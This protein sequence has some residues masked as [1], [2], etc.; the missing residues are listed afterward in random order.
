MNADRPPSPL[1]GAIV[2]GR[3]EG[4]RLARCLESVK[5]SFHPVVYVDS[6]S[7]DGSA[8]LAASL[9]VPVVLLT[10][11]GLSAARARQAGLDAILRQTPALDLVQFVDGDCV[12]DPGWLDA[13]V[14]TLAARPDVAAVS[15][16]RREEPVITGRPGAWARLV[17]AEWSRADADVAYPGGDSLC[18]VQALNAIGGWNVR[19]IA[20]EDPDLGFRLGA[21]G[22]KI[23]R[24][25]VPMTLHDARISGIKSYWRR[26]VRSGY[27]YAAAGWPNRRN[28]GRLYLRKATMALA[29][30]LALLAAP[31]GLVAILLG[32][33]AAAAGALVAFGLLVIAWLL[34]RSAQFALRAGL[35][36]RLILLYALL[37]VPVKFAQALGVLKFLAEAIRKRP[38]EL[39]EYRP[40]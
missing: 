23:R 18:R 34:A 2:I 33:N 26:A 12:L 28:A 22:W 27:A 25:A 29:Y 4:S 13:A 36:V 38:T 31:V 6:G 16:L 32:T 1:V 14:H 19:L 35:G 21:T 10:P 7:T 3:N 39:I 24:I 30:A 17:D 9:G 11:P 40:T 8:Q 37:A 5:A 15:G 20:G